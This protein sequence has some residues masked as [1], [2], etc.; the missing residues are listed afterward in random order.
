MIPRAYHSF[1]ALVSG[2]GLPQIP[3]LQWTLIRSFITDIWER[4]EL[5]IVIGWKIYKGKGK[6]GC[7]MERREMRERSTVICDWA[8]ELVLYILEGLYRGATGVL[9]GKGIIL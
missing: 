6:K 8:R 1:P 2:I 9:K 5:N 7:E 4:E 3:P